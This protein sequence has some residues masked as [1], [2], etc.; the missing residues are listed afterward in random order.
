MRGRTTKLMA[1]LMAVEK[2]AAAARV[3]DGWI[4]EAYLRT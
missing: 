2:D 1:W 4:S 3:L